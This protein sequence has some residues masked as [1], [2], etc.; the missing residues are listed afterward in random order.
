MKKTMK[1][2]LTLM[3]VLSLFISAIPSGLA[4]DG[5]DEWLAYCCIIVGPGPG[6]FVRR[7]EEFRP[8]LLN[9]NF[10][11][12]VL[13]D[14]SYECK[15]WNGYPVNGLAIDLSGGIN[16]R[17]TPDY[18]NKRNIVMKIHGDVTMYIYFELYNQYGTHWYYGVTESGVEGFLA[19]SRI[20]L[21]R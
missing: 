18:A 13:R 1:I 4:S 19:A 17:S 6:A 20:Q 2:A 3:L 10:P 11:T 9:H 8:W 21:A 16:L 15:S 14:V 7:P 12:R 5:Y